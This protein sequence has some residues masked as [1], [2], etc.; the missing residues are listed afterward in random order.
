MSRRDPGHC[1]GGSDPAHQR[2][3]VPGPQAEQ[4]KHPN[5]DPGQQHDPGDRQ[6]R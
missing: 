2:R 1:D 3:A 4:A 6:V 5:G